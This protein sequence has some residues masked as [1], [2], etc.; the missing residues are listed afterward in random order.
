MVILL[1]DRGESLDDVCGPG[2]TA[3]HGCIISEDRFLYTHIVKMRPN[4]GADPNVSG[5]RGTPLQFAWKMFRSLSFVAKIGSWIGHQYFQDV[6]RL[7]LDSGAD[8]SWVE[9]NGISIDRL[10][11]ETWCSMP[12]EKM[13]A[14]WDNDDYPYCKSD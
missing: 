7:L 2:G 9:P 10:T 5:P 13:K 14:R 11:I 3:L 12:E 6:M 4:H 1:L 8:P